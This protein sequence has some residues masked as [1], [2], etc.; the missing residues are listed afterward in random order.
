MAL[1]RLPTK[2]S[3][4]G[5]SPDTEALNSQKSSPQL[6]GEDTIPHQQPL[7]H[8]PSIRANYATVGRSLLEYEMLAYES[9]E[10]VLYRST[11]YGSD[12]YNKPARQ[13][14]ESVSFLNN[15]V[16]QSYFEDLLDLEISDAA[17]FIDREYSIIQN[18]Y[19]PL[20]GML[21]GLG[22]GLYT[23]SL[24]L[25]L[26]VALSLILIMSV[27]CALFLYSMPRRGARRRMVFAQL[28]ARELDYR[29]GGGRP[30]AVIADRVVPLREMLM[31][32]AGGISA[33]VRIVVKN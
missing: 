16:L 29:R 3:P 12:R 6:S 21:T 2:S 7:F 14:R 9:F 33:K 22:S 28:L 20:V 18:Y 5:S 23:A 27:P 10:A 11:L 13:F 25:P 24:G 19:F 32:A 30:Q 4:V 31:P 26:V 1:V 15:E 8:P 17:L